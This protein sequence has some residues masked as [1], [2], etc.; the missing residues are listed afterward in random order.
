MPQNFFCNLPDRSLQ[1]KP[2][3][4]TLFVGAYGSGKSEVSVN[5]A[6]WLAHHVKQPGQKVVL[7]DLDTINPYY[8]SADA[9]AILTREGIELIAPIYANTNI[10]VPAVPAAIFSVFD[11]ESILAV[12]DIGG[13]DLGARVVGSLRDRMAG[14]DIALNVVV[15]PYRPATDTPEGIQMTVDALAAAA[16]LQLHGIVDN[17]NLLELDN[18]PHL[19]DTL[20]IVAR[21]SQLTGLPL[22]F[23]TT[24]GRNELLIQ[25]FERLAAVA[26]ES[27]AALAATKLPILTMTRSIHYPTDPFALV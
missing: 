27:P 1:G 22:L 14:Q 4:I 10:E 9:R 15:N 7:C 25:A 19:I 11:N 24:L 2:A 17:A 23:A 16:G 13:E 20:P 21:A 8:R 12:L 5:F 3:R 26:K 6:I 18:Q